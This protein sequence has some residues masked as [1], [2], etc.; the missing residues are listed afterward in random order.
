MFLSWRP[1]RGNTCGETRV[2]SP[3]WSWSVLRCNLDAR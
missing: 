3:H 2:L 1:L